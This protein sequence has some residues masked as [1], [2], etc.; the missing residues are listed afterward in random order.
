MALLVYFPLL[1]IQ[2][3]VCHELRGSR[4]RATSRLIPPA[5]P[6]REG[7]GGGYYNKKNRS[8]YSEGGKSNL[9]IGKGF[10][11]AG[12]A[13]YLKGWLAGLQDVE[14]WKINLDAEESQ[15]EEVDRLFRDH[16]THI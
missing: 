13:L 16:A 11:A 10:A 6:A 3:S 1:R 14:D 2:T 9:N 12:P 15:V 7:G 4:A 5:K 8:G